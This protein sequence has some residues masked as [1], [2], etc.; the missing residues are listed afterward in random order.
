MQDIEKK[1]RREKSLKFNQKEGF[2]M[3]PKINKN[4]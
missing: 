2:V 4:T 3:K 1:K